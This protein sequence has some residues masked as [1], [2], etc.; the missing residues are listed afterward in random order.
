MPGEGMCDGFVRQSGA[1][2]L[3]A[4]KITGLMLI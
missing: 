1:K 3:S 4:K 2:K